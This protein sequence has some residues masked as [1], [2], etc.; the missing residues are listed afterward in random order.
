MNDPIRVQRGTSTEL[1][2]DSPEQSLTAIFRDPETGADLPVTITV[3]QG[4]NPRLMGVG[5]YVP[6]DDGKPLMGTVLR[7]DEGTRADP[8]VIRWERP[9]CADD[10]CGSPCGHR[11]R[12]GRR[13]S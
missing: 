5:V 7:W 11:K 6:G 2:I 12:G 1:G 9:H 10:E 3:F 4:L 13:R 8:R